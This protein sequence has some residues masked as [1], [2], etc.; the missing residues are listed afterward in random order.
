MPF[1][2]NRQTFA[3]LACF[4]P[5]AATAQSTQSVPQLES[6]VVTASRA[7]QLEK[8][9]LGD[10]TVIDKKELEKAGQS[11][12]TEVLGRQH[13]IEFY[14]S[15]GP[16]TVSGVYLR[17]NEQRHTLV[18]MDG[19]RINSS[20]TGVV[21]W[22]AIDTANIERIEIVRGAASSMYGSDAIG[23]VVN[24]ITKKDG[25]DR[26]LSAYANF[27][28]G[29]YGTVKSG[30]GFS[31]A[32]DGWDY[33][34]SSSM[35]ESSGF[36]ATRPE[37]SAYD[38]DRDGYSQHTLSGSLGYRWAAD[39]HIGITAYNGY[40]NGDYDAA[41]GA[42]PAYSITRQQVYSVTNTD[43]LT[44]YWQSVLRFG[45]SK[46]AAEDRSSFGNRA[47]GTNQRSY[48]WQNNV[49]VAQDQRLSI[50]LERLED[51]L[52]GH[53]ASDVQ[54]RDTN[55]AGLIYRGDF[56]AHHLQA[57]LRNDSISGYGKETTGGLAYDLDL[58]EKWRIGVA[59]NT[60]FQLPNF[61]QLYFPGSGN[62]NLKPEK[63]RNIEA[64]LR[65]ED[66]T[67]RLGVTA[68]QNRVKNLI[69]NDANWIPQNIARA[70]IKGI[71][72][73][74][75]QDYGNTTVRAS[76]D[77][78]DPRDDDTKEQ[79]IRRA[80]Q[81]YRL[82]A[83]HRIDALTVGAEYQYSS[84]RYDA[85]AGERKQLGGYSLVNLTA[86]YD[87]SKNVG[88]QVRWNNLFNKDYTNVYGYN[89]PGSN[90]FVNLSLRM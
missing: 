23:G 5:L 80:R 59:G 4:L 70:T 73:T 49:T 47:F 25:A 90:V 13:G 24:I 35:A 62:P 27:G 1:T 37:S 84:K 11:S 53:M 6:V 87:F 10:V 74:A 52:A 19:I 46:E 81:T 33:A 76:A 89:M 32:K 64:S 69:V 39:H 83:E 20:N 68:Y 60:G 30:V 56:G 38:P 54:Q 82:G 44:D 86:A 3:V 22:N 57:N 12:L 85:V 88:V 79:L 75:E 55:S 48:S 67:M 15:G 36:N 71:S 51:S 31:G 77:F 72:L 65:Y 63:S 8:D 16:Q 2:L 9:V 34:L 58:T 41:F 42:N 40:I 21:N 28:L 18:L 61:G 7:P 17:G 26:P 29:T 45:Y 14:S 50:V 43:D 66:D 78:V